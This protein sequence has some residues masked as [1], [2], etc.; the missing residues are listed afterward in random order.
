PGA[1]V[2]DGDGF[3]SFTS[4]DPG[5]AAATPAPET[6]TTAEQLLALRGELTAEIAEQ[7]A[8]ADA[9]RCSAR[10]LARDPGLVDALLASGD[11]LTPELQQQLAGTFAA[12][13]SACAA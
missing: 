8:H 1:V 4:C 9:A 10:L 3:V 6:I 12:S 2:V 7:G 13:A 11:T 5:T